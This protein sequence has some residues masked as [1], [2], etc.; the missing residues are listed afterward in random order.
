MT[1]PARPYRPA[2]LVVPAPTL[3]AGAATLAD[4]ARLW[5]EFTGHGR[6]A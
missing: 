1:R 2:P 4:L 3:H 5:A 6:T